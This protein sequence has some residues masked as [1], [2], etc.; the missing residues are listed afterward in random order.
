MSL[1]K[2]TSKKKKVNRHAV[3]IPSNL[4]EVLQVTHNNLDLKELTTRDT[5]KKIVTDEYN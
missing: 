5:I 4:H 2:K 1:E 3:S